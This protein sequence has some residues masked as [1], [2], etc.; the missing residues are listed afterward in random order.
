[1]TASTAIGVPR[2]P[3]GLAVWMACLTFSVTVE[4]EAWV[5]RGTVVPG[6]SV[7]GFALL[8]ASGAF[9]TVSVH[10]SEAWGTDNALI[11]IRVKTDKTAIVTWSLLLA[12]VVSHPAFTTDT[13]AFAVIVRIVDTVLTLVVRGSATTVAC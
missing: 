10:E 2:V 5:A 1:V 13:C 3:A 6:S 7:S 11:H 8:A 12:T 4:A 9:Y